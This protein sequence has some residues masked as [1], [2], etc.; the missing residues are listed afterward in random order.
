[1][2]KKDRIAMVE[3]NMVEANKNYQEKRITKVQ[4]EHLLKDGRKCI[5]E[6]KFRKP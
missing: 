1:M 5:S 6:I 3:R 2:K 4:L